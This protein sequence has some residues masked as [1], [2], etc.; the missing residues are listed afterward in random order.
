MSFLDSIKRFLVPNYRKLSLGAGGTEITD[1]ALRGDTMPLILI[2][3]I[4]SILKD[5]KEYKKFK[6]FDK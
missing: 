3:T 4:E 1:R 2:E 5:D 6:N